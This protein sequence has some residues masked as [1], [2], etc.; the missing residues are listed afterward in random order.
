M[1]YREPSPGPAEDLTPEGL[2]TFNLVYFTTS[3]TQADVYPFYFQSGLAYTGLLPQR[4]LDITMIA[5]GCGVYSQA[6]AAP[7][8]SQTA[9]IEGAYRWQVNGWMY[10][11]PFFQ[12]FSRPNGT[13]NV[14][15]AAI[16]GISMGAVF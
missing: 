2:K 10:A 9:V 12:Y 4:D 1:L 6:D 13:P 11:Q 5:L 7:D 14:A 16:L 15:N 8:R 3:E